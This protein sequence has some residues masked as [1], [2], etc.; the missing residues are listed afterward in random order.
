MRHA[1]KTK[2]KQIVT[3]ELLVEELLREAPAINEAD[4]PLSS[5]LQTFE[6]AMTDKSVLAKIVAELEGAPDDVKPK[7][8]QMA[9]E[10]IPEKREGVL[11]LIDDLTDDSVAPED[12]GAPEAKETLI[13]QFKDFVKVTDFAIATIKK[14]VNESVNEAKMDREF[15][16]VAAAAKKQDLLMKI[17]NELFPKIAKGQ[18]N[19]KLVNFKPLSQKQRDQVYVEFTKRITA[20]IKKSAV[21]EANDN[22]YH[23]PFVD[24]VYKAV[25]VIDKLL[26]KNKPPKVPRDIW[27]KLYG[28][29]GDMT[30]WADELTSNESV[31]EA[32]LTKRDVDKVE[33]V[34]KKK[35]KSVQSVIVH[36]KNNTLFVNY[37]KFSDKAKVRKSVEKLGYTYDNDG[38]STNAPRGIIGV[39]G[40]NWM[41]F[42]KESVNEFFTG[43]VDQIAQKKFKK[44]WEKLSP[45]EKDWVS[46]EVRK[47][48][49]S[50]NE[51]KLLAEMNE[52]EIL[53]HLMKA[54]AIAAGEQQAGLVSG[55]QKHISQIQKKLRKTRESLSMINKARAKAAIKQIKTGKRD[56]G[57]GKFTNK[58]FG[59]DK[60]DYP[61][62]I[63]DERDINKYVKF[64]LGESI[65]LNEEADLNDP[66]L[67]AARVARS[68]WASEKAA[69]SIPPAKKAA[70][71][72]AYDMIMD[73]RLVAVDFETE[74]K[75]IKDEINQ[76]LNDMEQEAEPEGGPIADRYGK[77][78]ERLE[79]EY[80][81]INRQYNGIKHKIERLDGAF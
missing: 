77:E 3:E 25:G 38:R 20:A 9:D 59:L 69:N 72:R 17:S 67:V 28:L 1:L 42:I 12:I 34:V 8:M 62:E 56:D 57:M 70:I 33:K 58:L 61:H 80:A 14:H 44:D 45:N 23:K 11:E 74:M 30:E 55:L 21:N 24:G 32:K 18:A 40:T 54:R 39:G 5:M 41:S 29:A 76:L 35:S 65:S 51:G 27:G 26:A 6:K 79:K 4:D 16:A 63:T 10:V 36:K 75:S 49:E 66:V 31:N 22:R 53:K 7:L 50:V 47:Q 13:Q 68:R 60:N 64:G 43:K 78:L 48:K 2:I 46:A 73:L 52:V 15:K 81:L 19:G 71:Q 37:T